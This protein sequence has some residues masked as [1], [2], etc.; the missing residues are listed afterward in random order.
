MLTSGGGPEKSEYPDLIDRRM[1]LFASTSDDIRHH[2]LSTNDVKQQ[3]SDWVPES[4]N[5]FQWER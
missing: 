1:P 2:V 3:R 5:G 4:N